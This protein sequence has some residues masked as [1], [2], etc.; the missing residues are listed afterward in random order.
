MKLRYTGAPQAVVCLAVEYP[1]THECLSD[2]TTDTFRARPVRSYA[3]LNVRDPRVKK[4]AYSSQLI[5]LGLDIKCPLLP[6][7]YG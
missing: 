4:N 3:S 1:S 7:S 5:S 2:G 6:I